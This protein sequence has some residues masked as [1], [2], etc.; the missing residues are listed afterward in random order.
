ML[1]YLKINIDHSATFWIH[2]YIL[3][4]QIKKNTDTA[5]SKWFTV[6]KTD[7]LLRTIFIPG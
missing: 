7:T 2:Q 4:M 1:S 3:D 6:I 5:N